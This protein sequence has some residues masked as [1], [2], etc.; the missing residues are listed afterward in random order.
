MPW[1][2]LSIWAACFLAPSFA[3]SPDRARTHAATHP[4]SDQPRKKQIDDS[5]SVGDYDREHVD[6]RA[7]ETG[8]D[9]HRHQAAEVIVESDEQQHA[10]DH[11]PE[12]PKIAHHVRFSL[13]RAEAP[14]LGADALLDVRPFSTQ[15]IAH[16]GW[17]LL[18][19]RAE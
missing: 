12:N 16:A 8:D 15:A 18:L 14:H 9:D 11:R 3:V 7:E 19:A 1:V 17:S 5:P 10:I 6:K 13:V 4:I 2:M